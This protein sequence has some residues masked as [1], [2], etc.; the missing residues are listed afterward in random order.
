MFKCSYRPDTF[1]LILIN[2]IQFTFC[3]CLFRTCILLKCLLCIFVFFI[4]GFCL[5]FIVF[6]V[7]FSLWVLNSFSFNILLIII[8]IGSSVYSFW[9][10]TCLPSH[11]SILLGFYFVYGEGLGGHQTEG[12]RR[13]TWLSVLSIPTCSFLLLVYPFPPPLSCSLSASPDF[14]TWYW[15]SVFQRAPA[16]LVLFISC[17]P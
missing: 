6:C 11:I 13:A 15:L 12:S 1:L 3:F 14:D 9:Y 7:R 10:F 4:L 16:A 17:R 2:C 8:I 5:S